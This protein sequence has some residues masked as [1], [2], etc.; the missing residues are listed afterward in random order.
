M[1]LLE[2]TSHR[3]MVNEPVDVTL[4]PIHRIESSERRVLPSEKPSQDSKNRIR[5]HGQD[6]LKQG[7]PGSV[8]PVFPNGWIPIV[9]SSEGSKRAAVVSVTALG[10]RFC[11]FRGELGEAYV[12]DAYCPHL[13]ADLS[14]GGT[15]EGDCIECPFHGWQFSGKD[16]ACKKIPYS[17]KVPD[18]ARTKKWLSCEVNAFIFVWFH[19]ENEDPYWG[20]APCGPSPH[21]KVDL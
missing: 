12:L 17:C 1:W 10:Q 15:V 8:P 9:E 21:R 18:V 3:L 6:R 19:A 11:V 7:D 2:K 14:A 5:P 13:G 20:D 16:G 4:V